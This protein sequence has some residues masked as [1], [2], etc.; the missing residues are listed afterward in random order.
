M[1]KKKQW[2][3]IGGYERR[4]KRESSWIYKVFC[5]AQEERK[6]RSF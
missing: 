4:K 2:I 6:S 5:G 1:R 3:A